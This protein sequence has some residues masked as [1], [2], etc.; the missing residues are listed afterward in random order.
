MKRWLKIAG[1]CLGALVILACTF[2][3]TW[4]FWLENYAKDKMLAVLGAKFENIEYGDFEL[5]KDQ[6]IVKDLFVSNP[7]AHF[8]LPSITVSFT[9]D[10][11][12]QT[13][14]IH[15]VE[16]EGGQ[17]KGE[18]EAFKKLRGSDEEPKKSSSRVD[19]SSTSISVKEFDLDLE[20]KGFR[21]LGTITTSS[22]TIK[23]PF[24]LG[25]ADGSIARDEEVLA[26]AELITTVIDRDEL[27][28][29]ELEL[30]GLKAEL[31]DVAIKDVEGSVVIK[32]SSANGLK[33]DLLGKTD[34]GQRWL[35]DGEIDRSSRTARGHLA[36]NHIKPSQLPFELPLDPTH[37]SI[38]VDLDITKEG[39]EVAARGTSSVLDLH[40]FHKKL[41]R[42]TVIVGGEFELDTKANL[43]TRE[44][45]LKRFTFQPRIGDR[46]STAKVEAKGRVLWAKNP[47]A[48]EF[49]LELHMEAQPCQEVLEAIPP[50]FAPALEEFELGGETTLDFKTVVKMADPDATVLEGGLELKKCK[51]IKVPEAVASL[52]GSFMH[53][54]RMKNGTVIE[55]PLIKGHILYA[56]WDRIPA[57]V[58]AAVLSTEDGGFWSHSG[59]RSKEF[60]ASLRRNVELGKFRRGAST[61]TM[62]MVKNVLLTHEK[63]ISRKMQEIFLTW[64]IEKKLSKQRILEI[65]LNVVEFGPGI[66]GISDAADHYFGKQVDELTSL[67]AAFLA[68]LL[69]RPVERHEMWCRGE[70]TDKHD[71]YIHRVHRRMLAKNRIT[72]E[73]F[74]RGE[75]EGITFS[76]FGWTSEASCIADGKRVS[77]GS[78][79]QAALSG[80]LSG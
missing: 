30:T 3:A 22:D 29:L 9:P 66:Y 52:E 76:R 2:L 6:V 45:E 48:R 79:I 41:A 61:L 47:K 16:L 17:A 12:E 10:F 43:E 62:Q 58:P 26:S 40:V 4:P 80:L 70:L 18:L 11:W 59:F 56:S 7:N 55:R 32:D 44:L 54:V 49:E 71:K 46:L 38:T 77:S 8:S 36:A 73:E 35:F 23:G 27:F 65:Y 60:Y 50:G 20:A 51:L 75:A 78:H 63:T 15:S 19:I 42:D 74:D 31:E 33:F 34:A 28:P 14:T 57:S 39:D 72:Q 69:P 68:T 25:L 37:G 5:T 13:V 53:L 21:A 67:E 64:V 1:I 24:E